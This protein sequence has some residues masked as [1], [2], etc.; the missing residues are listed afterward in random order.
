MLVPGQFESYLT[1]EL[2]GF[3]YMLLLPG[4]G[5]PWLVSALGNMR[6]C[7][8]SPVTGGGTGRD[9]CSGS[10]GGGTGRDG[11]GGSCGGS[12]GPWLVCALGNMR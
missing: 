10:R 6:Y 9:G 12:G 8:F 1:R 4:F 11:C 3:C 2:S 5:G 7:E